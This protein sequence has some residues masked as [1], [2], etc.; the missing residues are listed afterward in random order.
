MDEAGHYKVMITKLLPRNTSHN[1][2]MDVD[3]D[4]DQ[5]SDLM[6]HTQI[7]CAGPYPNF[8]PLSTDLTMHVH[9]TF[10]I[11]MYKE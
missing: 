3:E 7:L 5:N 11:Y 4:S 6:M 2:S 8:S 9:C 10:I 1:R